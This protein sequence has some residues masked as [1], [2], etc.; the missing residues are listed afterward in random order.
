MKKTSFSL[1]VLLFL[2][3]VTGFARDPMIGK[4]LAFAQIAVGGGYETVLNL[5][6]RGTTTYTGTFSLFRQSG[7]AWSPLIN[8]NA[9][10]NGKLDISLGPGATTT[11]K[12]TASG[13]TEAGFGT[14]KASN[15]N[16]TSF[17]EGTLTY[18]V[19]TGTKWTVLS[20]PSNDITSYNP[21]SDI[22]ST[23]ALAN[24]KATPATVGFRLWSEQI[25]RRQP[26]PLQHR[27]ST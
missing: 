23:F 26:I 4:D 1:A 13:T 14:I 19:K 16:N 10:N 7:Q 22:Y 3:P 9:I 6:H 27:M 5:A 11:L 8:G 17:L 12:L 18:F 20:Q 24:A 21:I 15:S 25:T 2:L